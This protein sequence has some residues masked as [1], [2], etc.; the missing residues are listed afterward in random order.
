MILSIRAAIWIPLLALLL[1]SCVFVV[2]DGDWGGPHS[3]WNH[4]VRGSGVRAEED[5]EVAEFHAI[6]LE[7]C[8][9]VL[10]KVGEASSIHLSGDDNLLPKV[11]TTVENGVLSVD[12]RGSCSFRCGLELVI[13]TPSLDGFTIEGSGDVKI[14]GL[15]TGNVEL[16]I[17]GSGTLSAQGT[18]ENLIGSIEGSGSL[19]LAELDAARADLSIEGSGSMDVRVAKMLRYSIE[20]SGDIR[21]SGEPEL[22]GEI[23]GSGSVEKRR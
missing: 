2:G 7:T 13:S 8:A 10:V 22:G 3:L 20:G 1:G 5:R 12:L 4:S 6:E 9:T 11:E 18:A 19:G 15:A 16:A 17:E 23:E 14:A 21:Y